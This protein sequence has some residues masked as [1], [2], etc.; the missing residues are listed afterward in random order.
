MRDLRDAGMAFVWKVESVPPLPWLDAIG[1]LHILRIL[2]EAIGN[3]LSHA[4]ARHVEVGCTTAERQGRAGVVIVI[5]DDGD[6]FDAAATTRGRGLANM[7]ARAEALNAVLSLDSARG[8]GSR[9]E[10]WLALA[11]PG[12]ARS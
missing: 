1:A 10:L 2:Q 6:G 12:P 11:A 9:L 8:R 7:R 3:I 4:G 5:A